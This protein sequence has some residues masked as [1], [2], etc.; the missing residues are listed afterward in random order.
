[1]EELVKELPAD[2]VRLLKVET[3]QGTLEERIV[4]RITTVEGNINEIETSITELSNKYRNEQENTIANNNDLDR[5]I[6][7]QARRVD[8]MKIGLADLRSHTETLNGNNED[9]ISQTQIMGLRNKLT[10]FENNQN[11]I[12][13][14]LM[15]L[16]RTTNTE[17]EK[18]DLY[19]E[20]N[21]LELEEINRQVG[22]LQTRDPNNRAANENNNGLDLTQYEE[23][24]SLVLRLQ[25]I[26]IQPMDHTQQDCVH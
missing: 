5:R 11:G 6:G 4:Q 10:E 17:K 26:S 21:D 3:D 9:I 14:E 16:V 23:K 13:A 7:E 8:E 18:N 12:H 15:K 20:G 1:M 2:Q 22:L 25:L 19:K 24:I